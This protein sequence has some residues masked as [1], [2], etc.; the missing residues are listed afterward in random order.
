MKKFSH[1]SA[2]DGHRGDT[3]LQ[4]RVAWMYH[5]EGLRQDRI[6]ARLGVSRIK[7]H[8]LLAAG[9]E[10]GIVEV[11]IRHPIAGCVSLERALQREFGVPKAVVVP[12]SSEDQVPR[13]IGKAAASLLAGL[14]KDRI[15]IAVGWGSTLIRVVQALAPRRLR[16]ATVV[17]MLGGLTKRMAL[18][19]Y[20]VAWR[21][22]DLLGATCYYVPAP[23]IVNTPSAR[24]SLLRQPQ[25]REV[26]QRAATADVALLGL[27]D[28]TPRATV[29]TTGLLTARE[30]EA[31]RRAGAVGDIL[32]HFLRRDGTLAPTE[33]NQRT[34]GLPLAA[35]HSIP[36]VIGVAGGPAKVDIILAVLRARLLTT[37]V[38][39]EATAAGVVAS[40]S[41]GPV[42]GKTKEGGKGAR[43]SE[44]V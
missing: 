30:R 23:W 25:V 36:Q 35:L 12:A 28:L 44:G 32:G 16:A 10:N 33:L 17:S 38:T 37:L 14:L 8:R 6:A 34:I 19:P 4:A 31:L 9:R 7:V 2:I 18:N 41:D 5:I 11:S 39:D 15:T 29:V 20:E 3:D 43:V 27:G 40:Q 13:V 21:L 1:D 22:A 42:T 26:F 24:A